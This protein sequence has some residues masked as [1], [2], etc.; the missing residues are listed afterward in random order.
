M[1]QKIIETDFEKA[2]KWVSGEYIEDDLLLIDQLANAPFPAE[3]RRMNFILLGFCTRGQVE[4][5]VDTVEHVVHPGEVIIVS[6]RHVVDH[7]KSSP[8]LQGL[9][10]MVSVPF[11]KEVIRDV[12]DL[13]A[14]F[15]FSRNHPVMKLTEREGEV[16]H[17]YFYAI[18]ERIADTTNHFRRELIRTLML[19]MFYDLSNVIYSFRQQTD[20]RKSRADE[21]FAQFIKMVEANC[22]EERR[23]A[24]YAEQL[25]ITPKYLS[26]TV[27][28]V[29]KRTPN[30]WI[31]NY[32]TL[33]IRV[34]LKTSTKS[35]KDIAKEMKFPNQSFL[36]K[37][38]K[39]HVGMSPSEYRRN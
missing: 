23:V 39:E 27:K 5:R 18:R 8:D 29:S 34:Q 25:G 19:A 11:F 14:L 22:K 26:E 30:E 16:F 32:V 2:K 33:E 1:N 17:R 10:M 15:I 20:Q 7:Y 4:Y 37:Y 12:S 3:P 35:I 36:G 6:E 9:C 31:D 38:F 24:W 28:H 21:I 13:S